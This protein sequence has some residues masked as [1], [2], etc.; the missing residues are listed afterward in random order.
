MKQKTYLYLL[1]IVTFIL[2]IFWIAGREN[3]NNNFFGYYT[4]P[5]IILFYEI[6]HMIRR[7]YVR[8]KW[9]FNVFSFQDFMADHK[10]RF[11]KDLE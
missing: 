4:L 3:E 10:A 1:S 7:R 9:Y 11:G 6:I 2:F 5:F 8:K